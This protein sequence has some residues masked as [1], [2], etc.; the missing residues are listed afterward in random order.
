MKRLMNTAGFKIGCIFLSLALIAGGLLFWHWQLPKFHDV[1]IELGE[2]L[3]DVSAFMTDH[4]IPSLSSIKTA[5][6][7]IPLD[8]V[9]QHTLQ[10][11]HGLQ[12]CTVKLTVQDTTAPQ[13]SFRDVT[14]Y[15]D[16]IPKPEDFVS[17]IKDHTGT[18]VTLG[19]PLTVPDGYGS[20][21]VT[22]IVTD[23]CGNV[24]MQSCTVYYVW[25]ERE[26]TLELGQTLTKEDLLLRPETDS[27]LL[28][29]ALLDQINASGLGE[30]TINSTD[31]DMVCT[32]KVRVVDT[33]APVLELK[34][35]TVYLH[36]A[37]SAED[38]IVSCTDNS[39][40]VTPKLVSSLEYT[41]EGEYTI[42]FEAVDASGNK[43]TVNTTLT[44]KQ[45]TVGPKFSG[46]SSMT[47]KKNSTPDYKKGVKAVDG[48]DG[49]VSFTVD[50]SGV[51]LSK[52]GSYV[53]KYTATD[54]A[55]NV[56]TYRRSITVEYD[57]ADVDALVSS[58]AKKLKADPEKLRD[59]VR[60][61]IG[62]SHNWGGPDPTVKPGPD[63]VYVW[64]G[65][66]N[67]VG[68][69]YVHAL[70]LDALLKEKGFETQVIWAKDKTHYWNIVKID[71]K[72]YHIDST[73]G[74]RHTKYSLMNDKQRYE[75]LYEPDK[76]Y[77][78]DW[79]RSMWPACP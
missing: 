53:V 45:D 21:E 17:T 67:Y 11:R 16:E 15:I 22:V 27:E 57:Q 72:W 8:R 30:Y 33:T 61:K 38:F 19:S 23:A 13:V 46:M 6:K 9:G 12:V 71:G 41:K 75:T 4:A 66:K 62:Y 40:P 51:N 79:D 63:Y 14:A 54:S 43:T 68:N 78:R 55:G 77:Q 70:C 31:G 56:T 52:A 73:P 3:P 60:D 36:K 28:D 10:L 42:T 58:I 76:H 47:V 49:T 65:F 7:D 39:G 18:T 32:C 37:V 64:Y 69:C 24:A 26:F 5:E 44:V 20:T 25:L 2:G 59:Y 1:T 34:P 35:A 74:V 48:L 50:S 29:Q